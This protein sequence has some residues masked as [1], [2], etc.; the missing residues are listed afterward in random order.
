MKTLKWIVIIVIGAALPW[1]YQNLSRSTPDIEEPDDEGLTPMPQTIHV[2]NPN[3]GASHTIERFLLNEGQAILRARQELDGFEI[4]WESRIRVLSHAIISVGRNPQAD[5]EFQA[6]AER[7]EQLRSDRLRL[8]HMAKDAFISWVKFQ[9][10]PDIASQTHYE[11]ALD[12]GKSKALAIRGHYNQLSKSKA[13]HL[14]RPQKPRPAKRETISD[15]QEEDAIIKES[16]YADLVPNN[17]STEQASDGFASSATEL[18]RRATHAPEDNDVISDLAQPPV[19]EPN[20]THVL[21]ARSH[22]DEP[23]QI[24][25]STHE[26]PVELDDKEWFLR[27]ATN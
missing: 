23:K 26:I 4:N 19:E 27:A 5:P 8:N 22:V 21:D 6:W 11:S 1:G 25:T 7:L 16:A 12:A 20:D 17:N 9:Q 2:E 18:K 13:P 15:Q 3:T 10:I 24:G 14:H